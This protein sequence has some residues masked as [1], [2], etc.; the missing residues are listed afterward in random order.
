MNLMIDN[1]E[2]IAWEKPKA[3]W[4]KLNT[5]AAWDSDVKAGGGGL[6]RGHTGE[7]IRGVS[8]MLSARSPICAEALALKEGLKLAWELKF[9]K[10][11]VESDAQELIDAIQGKIFLPEA[12]ATIRKI[13]QWMRRDW[14]ISLR[15]IY[16]EANRCADRLAKLGKMQACKK[17]IWCTPPAQLERL[18]IEDCEG[19][20]FLRCVH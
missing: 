13:R 14:E 18:I 3:D 17:T 16:R 19:R 12:D 20:K 9:D 11:E 4:C 15:H 8:V 6:L 7:W 2:W 5:D 1:T 10:V